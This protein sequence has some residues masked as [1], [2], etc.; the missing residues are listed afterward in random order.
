[1]IKKVFVLF[2]CFYSLSASADV[3]FACKESQ[4]QFVLNQP[5]AWLDDVVVSKKDANIVLSLKQEKTKMETRFFKIE[6][7]YVFHPVL[8]KDIEVVSKKEILWGLLSPGRQLVLPG[9][10]VSVLEEH[11]ELRQN[12]VLWSSNL[13]WGWPDGE[14][15]FWNQKLWNRGTPLGKELTYVA[16]FDVFSNQSFYGIGCYAATKIIYSFGM[17]DYY[18]RVNPNEEKYNRLVS[19]LWSDGDPLVNIE[20]PEM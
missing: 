17:L 9:C 7:E 15:A 18:K 16:L 3:S 12:I 4:A 6:P 10:D 20:P 11:V 8:K 1:M 14:S 2:C 13:E 19:L 5:K